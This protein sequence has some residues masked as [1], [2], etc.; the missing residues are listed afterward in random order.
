MYRERLLAA[1]TDVAT[2]EKIETAVLQAVDEATETAKK[3]PPPPLDIA[4]IDV[5]ADGGAAWRN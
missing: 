3:S 4:M 2:L 1:G 5:W